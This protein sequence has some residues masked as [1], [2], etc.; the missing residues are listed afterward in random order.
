[1][2][3]HQSHVYPVHDACKVCRHSKEEDSVPCRGRSD[4]PSLWLVPG[5]ETPPPTVSTPVQ[6]AWNKYRPGRGRGWLPPTRFLR[7]LSSL[8][9]QPSRC[10]R[11]WRVLAPTGSVPPYRGWSAGVS[12]SRSR[13]PDPPGVGRVGSDGGERGLESLQMTMADGGVWMAASYVVVPSEW[14]PN[15]A[16]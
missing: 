8:P 2:T 6:L 14:P 3:L 13:S 12:W 10:R 16:V 5:C 1:M 7:P 11:D 4:R 9:C 15:S